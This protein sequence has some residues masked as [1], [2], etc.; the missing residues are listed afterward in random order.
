MKMT[1]INTAK[2]HLRDKLEKYSFFKGISISRNE[3]GKPILVVY[4][5]PSYQ[6][7]PQIDEYYQDIPIE[8]K[9]IRNVTFYSKAASL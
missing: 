2:V 4:V 9:Y 7:D 6:K 3:A 8:I 1:K 5:D